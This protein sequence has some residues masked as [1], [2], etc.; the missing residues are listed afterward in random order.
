LSFQ[1]PD[2]ATETGQRVLKRL[3]EEKIIWF[4]T[5]GQKGI[6]QPTP[7]W[8]LWD[9]EQSSF[10]IYNR[11]DAKRLQHIERNSA[12]SLHFDSNGQG[13]N[14]IV[15]TGQAEISKNDPPANEHAAYVTKY[16]DFIVNRLHFDHARFA[17]QYPVALRFFPE[18]IRAF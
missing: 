18:H 16:D 12:V 10:L 3:Q 1:L 7:V 14:I 2:P 5:I 17:K 8:F 6:P 11:A 9:E 13:G 15:F 4:I